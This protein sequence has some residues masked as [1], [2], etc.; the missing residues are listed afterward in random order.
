VLSACGR[1]DYQA[2]LARELDVMGNSE[3]WRAG[4]ATRALR[5]QTSARA[6][7]KSA[8]GVEGRRRG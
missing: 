2:Q 1:K 7:S 6:T 4:E 5:P 3:M 8:K